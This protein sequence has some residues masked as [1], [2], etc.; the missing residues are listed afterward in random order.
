MSRREVAEPERGSQRHDGY[1][2]EHF[3]GA[4]RDC[5]P[6]WAAR[7]VPAYPGH[8]GGAQRRLLSWAR[9]RSGD[10]DAHDADAAAPR[11]AGGRE[12]YGR[13]FATVEPVFANVRANKRLDRFTLRSR[14]NVNDQWLLF[15]LWHNIEKLAHI[16]YAA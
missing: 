16:G 5:A 14:T 13:R 15:C 7:A 8:H 10:R 11:Y 4:P 3:H 9:R 12:Q 1:V 6:L 2:G